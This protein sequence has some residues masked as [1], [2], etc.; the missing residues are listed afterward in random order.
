[1]HLKEFTLRRTKYGEVRVVTMTPADYQVFV[2]LRYGRR[3]DTNRVFLYIEKLFHRIG[4]A[5]KAVCRRAGIST[6]RFHVSCYTATA[7]KI[8]GCK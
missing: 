3:L 6:L 8:V 5:F 2:E 4:I 1:M 7:T